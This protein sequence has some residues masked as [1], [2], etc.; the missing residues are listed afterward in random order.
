MYIIL[1]NDYE[2]K[3]QQQWHQFKL[4]NL[5]SHYLLFGKIHINMF[6]LL[7]SD[8]QQFQKF[9]WRLIIRIAANKLL[10]NQPAARIDSLERVSFFVVGKKEK[11]SYLLCKQQEEH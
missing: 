6:H 10:K 1:N 7:I 11:V 8:C 9:N 3:Q 2:S 4:A 5:L